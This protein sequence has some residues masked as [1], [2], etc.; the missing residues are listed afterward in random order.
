MEWVNVT[1]KSL[2]EAIDLALDNLGVDEAEAEIEILEE[3]KQGLFGRTRGHARVK[4]R[5][6]PRTTRPKVERG[7]G[8][9]RKAEGG[10]GRN[11]DGRRG[12]GRG[13]GKSDDRG[14]RNGSKASSRG[15]G[16]RGEGRRSDRGSGGDGRKRSGHDRGSNG[17]GERRDSQRD[18]QDRGRRRSGGD[19]GRRGRS[20]SGGKSSSNRKAKA[21]KSGAS[22][23]PA[24]EAT[25][26]EVSTQI[27]SFLTGLSE[28]F[29]YPEGVDVVDDGD[30]GLVGQV[31]GQ[32]GLLIGPKGRTLE[33]VQELTR[34]VVQRAAPSD[35]RIKVDVGGYR[36]KRVE[37][38]SQFVLTVAEAA[39]DDG[40]ERALEPMNAADR[41]VVHD[42]LSAVDGIETRSAGADPHRRVV[43][44]PSEGPAQAETNGSS[45]AE[46]EAEAE[47][48]PDAGGEEVEGDDP[49]ENGVDA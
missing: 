10:G 26:E 46:A 28:A 11:R 21:E 12:E 7:R 43:V 27:E 20:D 5:V 36:A 29:G 17:S 40:Q 47:A 34:V 39:K 38:L 2:P 42:A 48:D 9:R 19:E 23:A 13:G 6:K 41:K 4:A 33:A 16:G 8:R 18:G 44:V 49:V 37:A 45:P 24:K 14:D 35:I 1:A 31:Q 3:P 25:V 30:G 22:D 32:H 15:G